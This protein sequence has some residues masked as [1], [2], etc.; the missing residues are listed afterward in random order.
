MR[1]PARARRIARAGLVPLVL[2]LAA[3]GGCSEAR[4][5]RAPGE[6]GQEYFP[7]VED[8]RWTYQLITARGSLEIEVTARG[9]MAIPGRNAPVFV[10]DERH[11]GPDMAFVRS[12]PVAYTVGDGYVARFSAVDYDDEG[13]LRLLG[14]PVPA[15]IMPVNAEPGHVWGQETRMFTT[16]EGGGAQVAWRGAVKERTTVEVP[17]GTFEDVLEVRTTYGDATEPEAGPQVVYHDYYA[18][19]VGLVRSVT[20]DPSGNPENRIEKVL[21]S[22]S[23]PR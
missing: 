12:S 20:E 11:L 2:A 9:D 21:V 17:A 10:M 19:G 1:A 8:A 14:E 3:A 22:S 16:P 7:M 18:R 13:A 5:P 6:A 15:W 23:F 4:S